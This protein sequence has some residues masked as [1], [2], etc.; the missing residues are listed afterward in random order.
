MAWKLAPF[1]LLA[2]IAT[3]CSARDRTDL[4]NVC[5]D[6]K[7]HKTKPGPEDKLHD[8]VCRGVLGSRLMLQGE[9]VR[10][11]GEGLRGKTPPP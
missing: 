9:E 1:L 4:L 7:H 3:R 2:W 6:A 8:Q 5:M 11:V 10:V